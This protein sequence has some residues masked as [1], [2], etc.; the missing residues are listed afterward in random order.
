MLPRPLELFTAEQVE[1]IRGA[2]V[3]ILEEV[4]VACRHERMRERLNG[5]GA[6]ITGDR[7]FIP[8]ELLERAL[9]TNPPSIQIWNRSATRS[10]E[11]LSTAH[12]HS[13]GGVPN[14]IESTGSRR[15]ATSRDLEQITILLDWAAGVDEVVPQVTP[16]DVPP[17]IATVEMLNITVRNTGKPLGLAVEN[18]FEAAYTIKIGEAVRGNLEELRRR[19]F[20]SV[21]VSPVSPLTFPD[22]IVDALWVVA[23]AGVPFCPLACPMMGA[24][25]P[26]TLAGALAQQNAENLAAL[27]MARLINPTVPVVLSSRISTLNMRSGISIWGNPEVGLADAC[28]CQVARTYGLPIAV[29]GLSTSAKYVGAQAGYEKVMNALV[30][31]L[32]GANA[33][34]GV[35]DMEDGL[36]VSREMILIDNEIVLALMR[37]L[38]SPEVSAEALAFEVVRECVLA[39]NFLAHPHTRDHVRKGALFTPRLGSRES[40]LDWETAGR[41]TLR[42]KATR[43]VE[44]VLANHSP[45]ALEAEVLARLDEIMEEARVRATA[46]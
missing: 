45:D 37:L 1:A 46:G 15:E 16:K 8:G 35:G 42:E 19:P 36:A 13:S 25:C 31:A 20:F 3:R 43:M 14:V 27:I 30:A 39:G 33:L 23:E 32:A 22:H 10:L 12:F 7:V 5:A 38:E 4:G 6:R 40:W 18:A 2:T 17:E 21:S 28:A 34:S 29:S 24:T 44:W 11:L 41:P 9:A 26:V